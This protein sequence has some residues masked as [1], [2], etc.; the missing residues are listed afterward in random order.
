MHMVLPEPTTDDIK[1]TLCHDQPVEDEDIII[2]LVDLCEVYIIK[3]L[4]NF[5]LAI[6]NTKINVLIY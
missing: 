2:S 3:A 6:Y 5:V 4:M 1:L